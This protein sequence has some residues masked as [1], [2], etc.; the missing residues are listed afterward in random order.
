MEGG[1][2]GETA[3]RALQAEA[4]ADVA[5]VFLAM[6]GVKSKERFHG[7]GTA[8]GVEGGPGPGGLGQAAV[9]LHEAGVDAFEN[10]ERG[11]DGRL[12]GVGQGGPVVLV[13]GL[14]RRSVLGENEAGADVGLHVGVGKVVDHL[15]AVPAARAVGAGELLVRGAGDEGAQLRGESF[16]L[17]NER[18]T[19]GGGHGRVSFGLPPVCDNRSVPGGRGAIFAQNELFSALSPADL[20][21]L[22][23]RAVGRDYAEGEHLFY[24]GDPC[25]GVHL[26]TTGAVK[27][28]KTTPSGRQLVLATQPAPATVAEVPVFDG[29]PYPATVTAMEATRA[30]LIPRA[31]FLNFC[32]QRPELALRFLEVFGGRLR[33]LVFLVERITFGN[34]RQRLAQRLLDLSAAA[35]A[36]AFALEETHEEMASHLGTVREVVT[37]NLSRFQSEGLI[38]LGRREV[39]LLDPEGLRAEAE[40]EL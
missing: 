26:I 5:E 15:E 17:G 31:D 28:V 34:V 2:Q 7:K 9:E 27:I 30:Y 29:G 39:E 25:Q 20:D 40:T 21:Q 18:F 19:F 12:A 22:A 8:L 37:R 3:V 6:G 35:G 33:Q 11:L 38:R 23:M 10:G 14:E 36:N 16:E 4:L 13:V 32:K 1:C 24:E